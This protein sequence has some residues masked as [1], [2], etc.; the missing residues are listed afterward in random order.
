MRAV[1]AITLSLALWQSAASL[2]DSTPQPEVFLQ[3][4]HAGL[5]QAV[6]VSPD[7]AFIA[8]ADFS[9]V[10]KLWKAG[11]H[12]EIGSFPKV[13]MPVLRLAWA[14]D[15]RHLFAS[16]ADG[17]LLWLDAQRLEQIR[18]SSC[19]TSGRLKEVRAI[20]VS[21]D[22][23]EVACGNL[24]GDLAVFSVDD[25]SLRRLIDAG[26]DGIRALATTPDGAAIVAGG[27]G[28]IQRFSWKDG[29]R[30]GAFPV[31]DL[32]SDLVLFRN[33]P[34]VAVSFGFL[35]HGKETT[36]RIYH[37]D[38]G[39]E[40]YAL[41]GSLG[42]SQSLALSPD[43][44][45][46]YSGP[47]QRVD[48]G[49][50][51]LAAM[52]V[53]DFRI[54]AWDL[55]RRV[56]ARSLA[57]H[58]GSVAGLALNPQGDQL[59]SASWD[60]SLRAWSP[61]D[62]AQERLAARSESPAAVF[63]VEGGFASAAPEGDISVW[64]GSTGERV[65]RIRAPLPE[66]LQ[67]RPFSLQGVVANGS[68]QMVSV[69]HDGV[70]AILVRRIAASGAVAAT[71]IRA[72]GEAWHSPEAA[73]QLGAPGEGAK[74]RVFPL[75]ARAALAAQGTRVY[76]AVKYFAPG[77][78]F[79]FYSRVA[80]WDVGEERLLGFLP[81][82]IAGEISA[83]SLSPDA[84]T[85]FLGS[86][87]AL[88]A[89][90]DAP[91]ET[92]LS[93]YRVADGAELWSRDYSR[94]G[95]P[96][97]IAASPDGS[98]A[99]VVTGHRLAAFDPRSGQE[100]R[101]LGGAQKRLAALAFSPD[102]QVL[103]G[104]GHD[105]QLLAWDVASGE[106]LARLA[107][108]AG[109]IRSLSFL[110][111][112]KRVLSAGDDHQ[113]K[114]WDL[115]GREEMLTFAAFAGE[116]G[117]WAALTP[118]GYFAASPGGAELVGFRLGNRLYH[119]NQFY[120]LFYRPDLV[121][122]RLAG[123]PFAH[124]GSDRIEQAITQPP[125]DVELRTAPGAMGAPARTLHLTVRATGG[126]IGEV[127]VFHNGKL[128]RSDTPAQRLALAAPISAAAPSPRR[129]RGLASILR[130]TLSHLERPGKGESFSETLEVTP[131]AGDNEIAALAFNRNNTVHSR[132]VT[133]N[134]VSRRSAPPPRTF[135]VAVG[136]DRFRSGA[137]DSLKYAAKDARELA[138]FLAA[139]AARIELGKLT[140]VIALLDRRA[141]KAGITA[142]LESV[143]RRAGPQDALVLFVAT[144]GLLDEAGYF[145]LTHD[146]EGPESPHGILGAGEIIDLLKRV[147][148]QRQLL[149]LDT[150]HAG[151][152]N[153]NLDGLYDARI[154]VFA[155][156][157][158]LHVFASSGSLEEALDDVGGN[159][160]LT[161][162]LLSGL[163]APDADANDDGHLAVSEW[164]D[165]GRRRVLDLARD[166]GHRQT[167]LILRYG[168]D[169]PVFRLRP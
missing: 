132:I 126:G 70:D 125:P 96:E 57:G 73:Q 13:S 145:L 82:L 31:P 150:C 160:L 21:R 111:A 93:A 116:P 167:P 102:G 98:H 166:A 37:L 27:A 154:T 95:A 79:T 81:G 84:G 23:S 124:L 159:G 9:G 94:H 65:R 28:R 168:R 75:L 8:S 87:Q 52:F 11:S 130:P 10:T 119:L 62:G 41:T 77:N 38:S 1:L 3:L 86:S 117:D 138:T 134:F 72:D 69:A 61:A 56:I 29:R 165:F 17:R 63:A 4:G 22:G 156:N 46:L 42:G 108:H 66:A 114:M 16:T 127:R 164:G 120:D 30:L 60:G 90:V 133:T 106:L 143:A 67:G 152:M 88:R 140:D 26:G 99:A 161:S 40:D 58:G 105:A 146:F 48:G 51:T 83:L 25:G 36:L 80:V 121:R 14:P 50:K 64:D 92:R 55:E 147:P 151:G 35:F 135:L 122:R 76:L 153:P 20:A 47:F 107:G 97:L 149:I 104:G 155:R 128:V 78:L 6:A 71:V 110:A 54:Q 33:S 144:H 5:I 109:T 158:G 115:A 162:A 103:V 34:Q 137:R 129:T 85:L 43:E 118:Q 12:K 91:R 45:T 112:G 7:G 142:A 18:E 24:D 169:F 68:G 89:E 100:F 53:S 131:V 19:A 32:V 101:T 163:K 39:R 2:A 141:T 157:A 59:Y 139:R 148:A 44:K 74:R 136:V 15:G 49:A 123:E 113:I